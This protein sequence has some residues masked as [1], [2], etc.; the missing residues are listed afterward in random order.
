MPKPSTQ[1]PVNRQVIELQTQAELRTWLND[2]YRDD[3]AR[4]LIEENKDELR[5]NNLPSMLVVQGRGPRR[6]FR[7]NKNEARQV[8]SLPPGGLDLKDLGQFKKVSFFYASNANVVDGVKYAWKELVKLM[9]RDSGAAV[10]SLYIHASVAGQKAGGQVLGGM[11]THGDLPAFLAWA[12]RMDAAGNAIEARIRGP[13]VPYRRKISFGDA[14]EQLNSR[15]TASRTQRFVPGSKRQLKVAADRFVGHAQGKSL[16]QT[17]KDSQEK[18]SITNKKTGR[19]RTTFRLVARHAV[20]RLVVQRTRR[21]FNNL[22]VSYRSN[23]AYDGTAPDRTGKRWPD[24]AKNRY[25][26]PP[27]FAYSIFIGGSLN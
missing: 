19:K 12:K 5:A 8:S 14:R 21:K 6:V 20:H 18:R 24:A 22:Y 3:M 2:S 4:I 9:P 26:S 11:S 7:F 15:E 17:Y 10:K 23:R 25:I 13:M 27:G 16:A 1:A